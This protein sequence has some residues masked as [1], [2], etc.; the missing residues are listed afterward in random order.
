[1]IWNLAE[2]LF[3]LTTFFA[4]TESFY[5]LTAVKYEKHNVNRLLIIINY[6]SDFCTIFKENVGFLIV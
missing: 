6:D 5:H 2:D 1:M 4:F 3:I